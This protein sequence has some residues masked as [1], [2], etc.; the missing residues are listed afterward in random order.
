MES[1]ARSLFDAR[2]DVIIPYA[3]GRG[4]RFPA[5]SLGDIPVITKLVE[6]KTTPK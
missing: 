6:I 3:E 1:P 4:I 5:S 2:Q